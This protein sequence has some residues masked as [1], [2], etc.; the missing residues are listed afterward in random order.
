M[1]TVIKHFNKNG[2]Y[3]LLKEVSPHRLAAQDIGLSRRKRG[4]DSRWGHQI[5]KYHTCNSLVSIHFYLEPVWRVVHVEGQF[6][7]LQFSKEGYLLNE[8]LQHNFHNFFI[9]C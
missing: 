4:F 7:P 3:D 5:L 8:L 9:V 2:N 1:S 6:S